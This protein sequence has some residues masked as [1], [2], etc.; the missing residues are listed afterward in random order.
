MLCER[1]QERE[2]TVFHTFCTCDSTTGE[3][4]TTQRNLCED[5]TE[6][7]EPG[8]R[9]RM[10]AEL[11]KGCAYCGRKV[12]ESICERC[13]T[14]LRKI[15]REIGLS[16]HFDRKS[17]EERA[18]H[19]RLFLQ[20]QEEMKKWLAE[21]PPET[22]GNEE[23]DASE[24]P[25]PP[26]SI[27]AE[28]AAG[29]ARLRAEAYRFVSRAAS[30]ALSDSLDAG[31]EHVSGRDIALAFRALALAE[32]GKEALPTL[33]GWGLFTTDDVGTVVYQMIEVGL[34]G[35]RAEDKPEDFHA[36]Y[37]FAAEFPTA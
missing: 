25:Q 37:D 22:D 13:R 7:E 5:C 19:R 3:T 36:I 1:C 27:F 6:I 35:A 18:K 11:A 15:G 31:T 17:K 4:T 12:G 32:F 24:W 34:L 21:N 30:K 20:L 29:Q 33:N 16:Y 23:D 10:A 26:D 8:L 28:L 2:A 9:S 14:Q